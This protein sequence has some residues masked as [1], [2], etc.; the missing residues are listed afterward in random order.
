MPP[1]NVDP[2]GNGFARDRALPEGPGAVIHSST[3]L[4]ST[5]YTSGAHAGLV[6]HEDM[7][8][9]EGDYNRGRPPLT[10]VPLSPSPTEDGSPV[11]HLPSAVHMR[12]PPAPPAVRS[13]SKT[14]S[15][16]APSQ[17]LAK[18][19]GFIPSEHSI[20]QPDEADDDINPFEI[21][22]EQEFQLHSHAAHSV[23]STNGS[24][25]FRKGA[26]VVGMDGTIIRGRCVDEITY[27]GE[28]PVG[29]PPVPES[30]RN[31]GAGVQVVCRIRPQTALELAEGGEQVLQLEEDA[32]TV[33]IG[34]S[35]GLTRECSYTLHKILD[36][37]A[38]QDDAY[39]QVAHGVIEGALYGYNGW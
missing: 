30:V 38:T 5:T 8:D 34:G 29:L 32:A 23:D 9:D 16:N 6:S 39:H 2:E 15:P 27:F 22:K 26:A 4:K 21:S 24:F 35:G 13:R 28:T 36:P 33:S 19:Y 17:S 20:E 37:S 18:L 31:F 1:G 12:P 25:E 10:A 14:A 7:F 11:A 3:K